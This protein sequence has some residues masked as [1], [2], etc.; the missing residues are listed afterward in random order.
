[1]ASVRAQNL[2]ERPF[3]YLATLP[4]GDFVRGP[5]MDAEQDTRFSA[6]PLPR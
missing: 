4:A 2:V 5:E 3:G 1:M 6:F